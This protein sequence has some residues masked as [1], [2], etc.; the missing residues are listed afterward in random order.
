MTVLA[1]RK[2]ISYKLCND[3]AR[4][5]KKKCI[6]PCFDFYLTNHIPDSNKKT[7]DYKYT[8]ILFLYEIITMTCS[9]K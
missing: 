3:R 7:A 1:V 6:D 9:V 4:F 5:K 8:C 2:S